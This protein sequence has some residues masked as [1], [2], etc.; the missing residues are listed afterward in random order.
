MVFSEYMNSLPNVKQET[1]NM[2][3]EL[4]CSSVMTV[5]RWINGSVT[6]PPLKQKIIAGYLKISVK[7]LFPDG[8]EK[9][10]GESLN[11]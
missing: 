8:T 3:A 6:P 4:T 9:N 5:Y 1:I 7:E 11:K 10:V 2:L